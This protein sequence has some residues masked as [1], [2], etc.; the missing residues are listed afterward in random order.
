MY[1]RRDAR[2]IGYVQ[3]IAVHDY[4]MAAVIGEKLPRSNRRIEW[5]P[6]GVQK[7]HHKSD[8]KRCI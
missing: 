1:V 5:A 6:G 7:L 4:I 2:T 3:R 8:S